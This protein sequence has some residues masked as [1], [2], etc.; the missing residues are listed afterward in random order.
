MGLTIPHITLTEDFWES[1]CYLFW[2][3]MVQVKPQVGIHSLQMYS[4]DQDQYLWL[5]FVTGILQ[6]RIF[7]TVP[8]FAQCLMKPMVSHI[9]T[10]Y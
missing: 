4:S 8:V 2:G 10:V 7:H 1:V 5:G 6:V 9:P 3:P